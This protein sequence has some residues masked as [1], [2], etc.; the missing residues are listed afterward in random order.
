MMI[1]ILR[2]VLALALLAIGSQAAIAAVTHDSV[3]TW[4]TLRGEHFTVHYHDGAEARARE[5]MAIAE[6]VH[7]RL[8]PVFGW[9]P[10]EPTEIVVSDEFDLSQ[11]SASPFPANRIEISLAPPDVLESL[12][13]YA[14]WLELVIQHEYT[15]ILHIDKAR[16]FP[17]V[18]RSIFGRIPSLL[19]NVFPNAFQPRW[20]IE[21]LAVYHET[22][23]ARGVGRGQSSLFDM[24]M[25]MEVAGG[26]KPLTQINQAVDTWPAGIVPYLYGA[27]FYN[28]IATRYGNDAI[29]RWV[30]NYSDNIIP[31]RILSNSRA[32]VGRS[33][34]LAWEDFARE[35]REHYGVQLAVIRARGEHAGTRLTHA[36]YHAAQT[37]A[38]AD[39]TVFYTAFDGRTPT[40]LMK[41]QPGWEM[42]RRLA[43]IQRFAR[44]DVH[45]R[46]GVLVAQPE[47]CRNA[48]VTYDL[49][50]VDPANGDTTRLT[51][52]ARYRQ[53]IWHPEGN[54]IAAVGLA[55]GRSRLDLLDSSATR[56]ET[57]WEG[58]DDTVI[59]DL[60][61]SPDG[62]QIVAAVWRRDGGWN[63]E[64]FSIAARQWRALTRD[65]AIEMQPRYTR[66]GRSVLYT[67]DHGGVYN[68]RRLDLA[69]GDV[70]TVTNVTGGA[71]Y[72]SADSVGNIF[73]IGYGADGHDLYRVQPAVL[74]TPSAPPNA[75]PVETAA[76][77][78]AASRAVES[79]TPWNGLRPRWWLPHLVVETDRTEV[80]AI[81]AGADALFRHVYAVDAAYDFSQRLALGRIDYVY[82][83]WWPVLKLH[84]ERDHSFTR[85][86]NDDV[87]RVRRSD[88]I[89][90]EAV[91]PWLRANS[92]FSLHAGVVADKESDAR[93]LLGA[94][95]LADSRDSLFGIAALWD[96]A[97][98]FPLSVSRSHGRELRVVAETSDAFGGDFTGAIYTLDGREFLALGGEHV[99][100]L[101]YVGGWGTD[102]PRP[103]A[104]GGSRGDA[105]AAPVQINEPL[106]TPFNVRDYPLRGY[107]EGL[108]TLRGRRMQLATIEWRFPIRRVERGL[109]VPPVALH[110]L[111]GTLFIETGDAWDAAASRDRHSSAGVEL[112]TDAAIF[113]D[114]RFNL[115]LGYAHGF[116]AG[117]KDQV[118]LRIGAS[119]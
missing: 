25:R 36:G 81:T 80:G 21:G 34:D 32:T 69:T 77:T 16:G 18:L 110:Q 78:A 85:N 116:D 107:P 27:Q 37:R 24:Y 66:D 90:A 61:W 38:L 72:P 118:Y 44:I 79:Y 47:R 30:E 42:P 114:A 29:A 83:R 43:D 56:I 99:L 23:F 92:R 8:T 101:R 84:A 71:F 46:A 64:L 117:G 70:T 96:S 59:G 3:L 82:D 104:L 74:A 54:R 50:R 98:R 10:K 86:G 87:T 112:Q 28:Y 109:M 39:G 63:I 111:A 40:A 58:T 1:S 49:Y 7:A 106:D 19:P 65:R 102:R 60:D 95:P 113:Y 108:S 9:T 119:F 20:L 88:E 15:H 100:G 35:R 93:L 97:K 115:R 14:D 55:L 45:P 48:K 89:Q 57:L 31:Y 75:R 53:A 12:E 2:R 41:W 33:L 26:M 5:V 4:H 67:S 17:R 91:L 73:Y 13:A 94:A 103:F 76:P 105:S 51:H 68:L 6:R 22:D 62:A 11:G 52:C